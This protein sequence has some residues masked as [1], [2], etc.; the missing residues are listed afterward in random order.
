MI[1]VTVQEA[2]RMLGISEQ[3]LRIALRQEKFCFGTAVKLSERRWT[4]YI[5]RNKLLEYLGGESNGR[6]LD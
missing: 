6:S 3:Y 2:A 4:Y 1:K 5:N